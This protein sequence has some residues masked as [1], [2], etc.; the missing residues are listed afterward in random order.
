MKMEQSVPKRR[1]I[2]F[3]RQEITHKKTYKNCQVAWSFTARCFVVKSE[4][5]VTLRI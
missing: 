2:K 3:R 4:T 5:F 1:H